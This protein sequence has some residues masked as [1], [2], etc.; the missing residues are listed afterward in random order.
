MRLV[1]GVAV[2]KERRYSR[3]LALGGVRVG[4]AAL[5]LPLPRPGAT[6]S[7]I[8]FVSSC[9]LPSLTDALSALRLDGVAVGRREGVASKAAS[10]SFVG[11]DLDLDEGVSASKR[12][13]T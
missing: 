9:E 3:L 12:P 2:R 5:L 11:V 4:F 13:S 6:P 10:D 8:C 7:S 1:E